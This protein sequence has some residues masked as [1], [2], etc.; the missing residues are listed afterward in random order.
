MTTSGKIDLFANATVDAETEI[1]LQLP[2]TAD[3]G[4]VY[5][6]FGK[7]RLTLEFYDAESLE[8]LQDVAREG[9]ARLRTVAEP[10]DVIDPS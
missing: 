9:A 4:T 1:A 5:I 8:R 10:G 2:R 3:S 6:L 7:E